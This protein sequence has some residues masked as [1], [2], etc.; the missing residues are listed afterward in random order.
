MADSIRLPSGT[1][2]DPLRWHFRIMGLVLLVLLTA[3]GFRC[4][5]RGRYEPPETG[6]P[7]E[8][9]RKRRHRG[10]DFTAY[11]S[12]GEAVRTGG[13][14]YTDW[15]HSSTPFR[16]YLYPPMFAIFPMA[17]LTL[18]PHNAALAAFY[19][20]NVVL[21]LVALGLLKRM[22]WQ[23]SRPGHSVPFWQRPE[24]GLFGAA[25]CC[26]RF[27]D[28]NMSVG[29]ANVIVLFLLVL[30][31]WGVARKGAAGGVAGGMAVALAT[32]FKVAP[33]LFGLYF[34][35]S[36]RGWA[37]V[38]GAVGLVLFLW[39]APGAVLGFEANASALEA[40]KRYLLGHAG[41]AGSYAP[42]VT[43]Q[44]EM[45]GTG[46]Q[47]AAKPAAE[48]VPAAAV[49]RDSEDNPRAYGISLRGT[50]QKL[51]SETVALNHAGP[52]EGQSVNILNLKV[53]EATGLANLVG[54][55][56]LA[57]C[58]L[59][60]LPRGAREGPWGPALS[61]GLLAVTMLLVSPLTRKAHGVV[62]VIPAAALIAMLQQEIL[63]GLAHKAAWLAL[64]LLVAVGI[65]TSA[66]VIGDEASAIL[67]A[68]G[69]FTWTFLV[70]YGALAL[71]LWTAYAEAEP[72]AGAGRYTRR[73]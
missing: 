67:H 24:V 43:P 21:L 66:D 23:P 52:G 59:L 13:D 55:A 56:L 14:V 40:C 73:I 25:L 15:P 27:L 8:Q 45:Q 32:V 22:L 41:G 65:F 6:Q 51:F 17:P 39:L 10:T 57:L 68:M 62:L 12:A 11:Y 19:A 31:L 58:V 33:G 4:V 63:G 7:S 36:R 42:G 29:N 46:T 48:T 28:A 69:C 49:A 9:A 72:G 54:G 2:P 5:E 18:L 20:L 34:A 37:M 1:T 30:G 16:P 26:G 44:T 61:W 53:A 50:F 47:P 70:L 64:G 71:A 60:T 3:Y 38:G 35:W